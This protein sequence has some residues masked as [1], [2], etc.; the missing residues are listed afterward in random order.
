MKQPV[1]SC[2]NCHAVEVRPSRLPV[3]EHLDELVLHCASCGAA[4]CPA[5]PEGA[6]APEF[7]QAP[8]YATP[9]A[10]QAPDPSWHWL[11]FVYLDSACFYPVALSRTLPGCWRLLEDWPGQPDKLVIPTRLEP[12]EGADA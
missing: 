2:P 12:R 4:L 10:Q 1:L 11:G 6:P 7:R 5:R 9:A 8:A 3:R